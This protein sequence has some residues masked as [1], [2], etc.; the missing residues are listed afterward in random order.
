MDVISQEVGAEGVRLVV[1][2]EGVD[3][4]LVV[5]GFTDPEV[6]VT[7]W[8]D[9][10]E[11]DPHVGGGYHLA[12]EAMGWH[13]RGEYLGLADRDLAFT[14]AWDH[15]DQP[16]RTVAIAAADSGHGAEVTIEHSAGSAEEAQSYLDG[17]LHF[18]PRLG[19]QLRS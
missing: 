15:E 3:A 9:S 2:F 14:W 10:A 19:D 7:W 8:P 18:L 6:L 5:A 13:L 17:W 1:G 11:T 4:G 12:W 16:A